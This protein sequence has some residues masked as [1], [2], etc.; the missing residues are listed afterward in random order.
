[1]NEKAPPRRW[2]HPRKDQWYVPSRLALRAPTSPTYDIRP[3]CS[4]SGSG[5][6]RSMAGS[7]KRRCFST[8]RPKCFRRANRRGSPFA[9][10]AGRRSEARRCHLSLIA[11]MKTRSASFGAGIPAPFIASNLDF[12]RAQRRTFRASVGRHQESCTSPPSARI[13]GFLRT[14]GNIELSLSR[15]RSHCIVQWGHDFVPTICA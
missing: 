8:G 14:H 7:A 6:R 13:R 9:T 10:A 3:A 5:S 4:R 15:R 2:Q 1:M 12:R 11:L